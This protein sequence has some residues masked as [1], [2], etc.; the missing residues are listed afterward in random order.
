MFFQS[1]AACFVASP[2]EAVNY[3]SLR[4]SSGSFAKFAAI[5]R[6][7]DSR[8]DSASFGGIARKL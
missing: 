8:S 2:T 3:L 1:F 6:S 5:R 4:N 7:H